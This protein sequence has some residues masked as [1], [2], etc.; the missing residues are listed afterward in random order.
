MIYESWMKNK[1]KKQIFSPAFFETVLSTACYLYLIIQS[2]YWPM[3]KKN[4]SITRHKQR[5]ERLGIFIYERLPMFQSHVIM[6]EL[7][8]TKIQCLIILISTILTYQSENS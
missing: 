1:N 5:K 8:K 4:L 2:H 3:M 7:I 6:G